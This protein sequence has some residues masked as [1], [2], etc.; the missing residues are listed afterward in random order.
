MARFVEVY[1]IMVKTNL[2]IQRALNI[3]EGD[4]K[5]AK[6]TGYLAACARV[7]FDLN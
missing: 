3:A 1:R 4:I 5:C 6:K 7:I 2:S